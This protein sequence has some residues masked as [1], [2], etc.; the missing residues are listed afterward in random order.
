MGDIPAHQIARFGR[1]TVAGI[2]R[3]TLNVAQM[4]WEYWQEEQPLIAKKR[5]VA[6]FVK[7][8]D[9]LRDDTERLTKRMEKLQSQL[10]AGIKK[11]APAASK[12][13]TS[14]INPK[15]ESA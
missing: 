13:N 14:T 9:A 11:P 7:Q 8:V 12:A 6:N 2:K 1:N 10:S 4:F 15:Q 5:H 3:Q